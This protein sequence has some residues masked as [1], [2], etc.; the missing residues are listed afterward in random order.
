MGKIDKYINALAELGD[1]RYHYWDGKPNGIGCSD[2]TRLALQKAGIIKSGESF[3]AASNYPGVL[4]DTKRFLKLPW[5]SSRLQKG[6]ILWSAG[7][8][9]ATWDGKN[10]VYE[11]APEST[12]GIC[13]NGKTGVGH[14]SQHTYYNCGTGTKSWTCIYR[15]IEPQVAKT[16]IKIS[17]ADNVRILID[18]LPEIRYG[19]N[20]ET[21]KALQMILQRYGW[22]GDAIDGNA[23]PNTVKGIKLMQT[24]YNLDVD[25]CFGRKCWTKLLT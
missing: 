1:G 21:V 3:H 8:H 10:G 12:H 18:Y 22:Y 16:S 6:D 13:D 19:S 9:V 23:G 7:H 15:I 24:A 17:N 11:A 14:F 20:S 2:Y 25:G 5:N 4:D